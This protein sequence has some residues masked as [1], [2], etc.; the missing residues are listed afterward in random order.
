MQRQS[1][2]VCSDA[3][4]MCMTYALC[5]FACGAPRVN[6]ACRA[7]ALPLLIAMFRDLASSLRPLARCRPAARRSS[8]ASSRP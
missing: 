8:S 7:A 1:P 2:S 4:S 3:R 5:S 6:A